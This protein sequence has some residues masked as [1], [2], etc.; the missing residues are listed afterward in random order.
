MIRLDNLVVLNEY[1]RPC[2]CLIATRKPL[3]YVCSGT[4]KKFPKVDADMERLTP[5]SDFGFVQKGDVFI[6]EYHSTATYSDG[7]LRDWQGR[8][9]FTIDELLNDEGY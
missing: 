3:G 6:R 8:D 4:K 2:M 5:L 9:R 1:D 7:R